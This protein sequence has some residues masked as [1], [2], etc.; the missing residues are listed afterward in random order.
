M[1]RWLPARVSDR[2]SERKASRRRGRLRRPPGPGRLTGPVAVGALVVALVT[3]AAIAAPPPPA[4]HS[5]DGVIRGLA[6]DGNQIAWIGRCYGLHL[7]LLTRGPE[8]RMNYTNCDD[9]FGPPLLALGGSRAI[10]TSTTGSGADFTQRLLTATT[11]DRRPRKLEQRRQFDIISGDF[12]KATAGDGSTLAYAIVEIDQ[13]PEGCDTTGACQSVLAGGGV[14]T[15]VGGR[16]RRL[17]GAPPALML[18]ASAG[19]LAVVPAANEAGQLAP[20]RT[21]EIRTATTGALL[22][23]FST[24]GIVRAV[25]LSPRVAAVV[26]L[27]DRGRRK[28]IERYDPA[29]GALLGSTSA[30]PQTENELDVA[31]RTIVYRSGRLIRRLDALTGRGAIVARADW[32]LAAFAIE[33]DT[34]AW[35]ETTLIRRGSDKSEDTHRSRVR[36]V[37]LAN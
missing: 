7:R 28:R 31:D 8:T 19:R 11:A 10:W 17:P 27:D 36:T 14:W 30:P 6:Y 3:A 5:F 34:V 20:P 12:I 24:T 15:V 29:S 23:S 1:K 25:A 13:I 32:R 22:T 37:I 18:A 26:V 35:V 4:R 16:K 9:E 21:V 2:A 33:G